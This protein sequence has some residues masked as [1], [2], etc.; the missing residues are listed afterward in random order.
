MDMPVHRDAVTLC[1]PG[2]SFLDQDIPPDT[3][4]VAVST[5]IQILR[6][7]DYWAFVDPPNKN[8]G[9]WGRLALHD[10][11][12]VKVVPR[13]T[14]LYKIA[15]KVECQNVL[16]WYPE[17]H[18]DLILMSSL[19]FATG[20]AVDRCYQTI[21]FLGVDQGTGYAYQQEPD[22]EERQKDQQ[23]FHDKVTMRMRQLVALHPDVDFV[24]LTKHSPFESFMRK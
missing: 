6:R 8:H 23:N 5:A 9:R 21:Y 11:R 3:D 19:T 15:D 10:D 1:C 2:P 7:P 14:Y 4:V 22:D 20:W 18:G 24:C 17:E 16:P 13:D 12:V